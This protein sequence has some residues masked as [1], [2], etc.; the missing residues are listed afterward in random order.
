MNDFWEYLRSHA[1]RLLG[2]AFGLAVP[3]LWWKI[4][5]GRTLLLALS[6]LIGYIIGRVIDDREWFYHKLERI[7]PRKED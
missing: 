7:L 2:M 6:V 1:A 3:I 5:F 4:G